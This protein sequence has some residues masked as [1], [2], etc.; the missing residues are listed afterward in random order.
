[1]KR[2]K[3]GVGWGMMIYASWGVIQLLWKIGLNAAPYDRIGLCLVGAATL[4]Y[5]NDYRWWSELE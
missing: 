5:L 2:L 1:M 4:I 3:R